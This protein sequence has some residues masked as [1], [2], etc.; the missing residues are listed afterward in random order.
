MTTSSAGHPSQESF[1]DR[2]LVP[3]IAIL[4]ATFLLIAGWMVVDSRSFFDTLGPFGAYNPHYIGD[5][6]AFQAGIGVALAASIWVPAFRSGALLTAT[7]MAG[8]HAIN[9]WID[10]NAANGDSN[11]DVLDAVSLTLQLVLTLGLLRASIRNAG[12]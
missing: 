4:A 7:A 9:H 1:V 5:A 3:G 8:F 10:V 6:A 11:A 2:A 12:A